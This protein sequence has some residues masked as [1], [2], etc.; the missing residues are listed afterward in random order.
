MRWTIA[1]TT[2]L[3]A[4][5][6]T[7]AV[8]HAEP[9]SAALARYAADFRFEAIPDAVVARAKSLLL[10]GLGTAY[11]ATHF[12]FAHRS[13]AAI[14]ALAG[15]GDIPVIGFR[16][17]LPLRDAVTLNGILVHGLDYDD[18]HSAGVIHATASLLPC[19]LGLGAALDRSGRELL[20]AYVLGMETAT[21][22]AAV[23]Q[24]GFHQV[25]FHP[26]GLIGAFGCALAAGH[27]YGLNA[28]ALAHAQGIALSLAAGS[29]EFLE[30]GAWTKRLHPGWAAAAGIT[31]AALASQ[32]FTGATR[33]Y[34]GRF[35]LYR[36]HLGN[37]FARADLGL[38]MRALGTHWETLAVAVKPY[39]LCHFVHALTDCALALRGRGLH[40]EDIEQIIARV[41]A[42][43]VKTVC[44]PLAAKRRPANDYD[45]KF[46]VPYAVA[47]ALLRGRFG[48]A[49]LE[50]EALNDPAAAALMAR[51]DYAVDPDSAFPIAYSGELCV[52]TRDGREW[53]HRE[54][55]NRGAADRPLGASDI[56]AKF[57]ENAALLMAPRQAAAQLEKLAHIERAASGRALVAALCHP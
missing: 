27:L 33:A 12:D 54:H 32:G 47:T 1:Q 50:T 13:L 36:S 24:G 48:L 22:L 10:D 5:D 55:I 46:S 20:A 52:R 9:I 44:E 2:E 26:T 15:R 57:L 34:E 11:A 37:E 4:M 31:A 53:T 35:G 41:P 8:D 14:T 38:A 16:E 56:E 39:P 45:A 3:T 49:E 19:V 42:E 6:D 23:A 17:H 25:G 51:V 7:T 28:R 18:T 40:A 43:V 30:D 21:R 29:M